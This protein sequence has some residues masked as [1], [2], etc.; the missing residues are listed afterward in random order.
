MYVD[1]KVLEGTH[2]RGGEW[3]KSE[4]QRDRRDW[5][6]PVSVFILPYFR[7]PSSYYLKL[8]FSSTSSSQEALKPSSPNMKVI[9]TILSAILASV[10]FHGALSASLRGDSAETENAAPVNYESF[11]AKSQEY[12]SQV[13]DGSFFTQIFHKD[14][15]MANTAFT[16]PPFLKVAKKTWTFA[17]CQVANDFYNSSTAAFNCYMGDDDIGDVAVFIGTVSQ[18]PGG[19]IVGPVGSLTGQL[20]YITDVFGPSSGQSAVAALD[21]V[22]DK[23]TSSPY[24]ILSP[25]NALFAPQLPLILDPGFGDKPLGTPYTLPSGNN[26]CGADKLKY[27]NFVLILGG[28]VVGPGEGFLYNFTFK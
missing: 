11:I 3:P 16:C 9:S 28:P 14:R 19:S 23:K 1:R 17:Y 27:A 18:P 21:A 15:M 7:V 8:I 4:S 24:L 25:I 5:T 26:V 13:E 20:I 12:L 2:V 10:L 22:L 6:S